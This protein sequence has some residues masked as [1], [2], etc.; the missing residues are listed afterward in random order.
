VFFNLSIC[1]CRDYDTAKG[2]WVWAREAPP[3]QKAPGGGDTV[4][5]LRKKVNGVA[6]S[7]FLHAWHLATA[8]LV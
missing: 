6:L 7:S 5:K 1:Q 8:A 3:S 4:K 2:E